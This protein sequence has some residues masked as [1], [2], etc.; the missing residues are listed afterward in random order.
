METN[1]SSELVLLDVARALL[2]GVRNRMEEV[3]V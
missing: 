2:K 1:K 3:V